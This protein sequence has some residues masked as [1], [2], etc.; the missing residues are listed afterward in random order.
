[1]FENETV[2]RIAITMLS[3][4]GIISFINLLIFC[5]NILGDIDSSNV[6]ITKKTGV[7]S[8]ILSGLYEGLNASTIVFFS[9]LGILFPVV[10]WVQTPS[11]VLLT[12]I[13]SS[14]VPIASFIFTS[15]SAMYPNIKKVEIIILSLS[16]ILLLFVSATIVFYLKCFDPLLAH[17]TGS[18]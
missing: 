13:S 2:V 11:V 14:A 9:M 8:V 15:I 3:L 1:M 12:I 6:K 7:L 4:I 18:R 17:F 5:Y 10:L 16:I